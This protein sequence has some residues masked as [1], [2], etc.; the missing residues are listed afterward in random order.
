MIHIEALPLLHTH[1]YIHTY[2]H[3][4][5]AQPHSWET[6]LMWNPETNTSSLL[7]SHCLH[8]NQIPTEKNKCT[9]GYTHKNTPQDHLAN[10]AVRGTYPQAVPRMHISCRGW[11]GWQKPPNHFLRIAM[12]DH[13]CKE[14]W[15][16]SLFKPQ[17]VPR[18]F[19]KCLPTSPLFSASMKQSNSWHNQ[20]LMQPRHELHLQQA[21][22]AFSEALCVGIMFSE[23]LGA[24]GEL[25][26]EH[27]ESS[28][29]SSWTNKRAFKK[30]H[31]VS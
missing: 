8:F 13:V 16:N 20:R 25:R 28:C 31:P 9:Q 6:L 11:T 23:S 22:S 14:M 5:W 19:L 1:T 26:D 3:C 15:G 17:S 10:S 2:T 4:H 24:Q 27:G 29:A 21:E 30:K 7:D 18:C 12:S